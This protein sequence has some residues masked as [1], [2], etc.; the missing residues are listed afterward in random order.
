MDGLCLNME[1][2]KSIMKRYVWDNQVDM[3]IDWVLES[4]KAL[5]LI[6]LGGLMATW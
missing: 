1:L 2:N 4:S 3:I 6:L 5:L